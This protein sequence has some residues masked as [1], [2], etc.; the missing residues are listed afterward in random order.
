M[1]MAPFFRIFAHYF[2]ERRRKKIAGNAKKGLK[3]NYTPTERERET[4]STITN[5]I[6]HLG[7]AHTCTAGVGGATNTP[8]SKKNI[9]KKNACGGRVGGSALRAV[10]G[11]GWA[12]GRV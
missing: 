7:G 6:M 11:G 12:A 1:G 5:A 10:L 4:E 9:M 8:I 3:K 2:S